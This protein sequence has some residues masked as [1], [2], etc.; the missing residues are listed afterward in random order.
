MHKKQIVVIDPCL[1]DWDERAM[2]QR[3]EPS[4]SVI[5]RCSNA[6]KGK[7]SCRSTISRAVQAISLI[8]P[9]RLWT[10]NERRLPQYL[11]Q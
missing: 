9:S 2:D 4:A 11:R 1:F 3:R 7:C 8:D 6:K 5:L 10:D